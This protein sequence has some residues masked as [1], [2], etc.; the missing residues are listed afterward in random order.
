MFIIKIRVD[1]YKLDN[2]LIKIIFKCIF[3]YNY[4]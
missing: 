3:V 2:K 4:K 1:V